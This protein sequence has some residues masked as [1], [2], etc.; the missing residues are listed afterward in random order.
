MAI[1]VI[2]EHDN[3]S[4]KVATLTMPSPRRPKSV[5]TIHL[6]VAGSNLRRRRG[7]AAAKVAGVD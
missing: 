5:L 7:E 1:L 3:T 6:L 2:A 4:L